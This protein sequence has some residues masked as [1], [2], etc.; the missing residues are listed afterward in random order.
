MSFKKFIKFSLVG[1]WAAASPFVAFADE[2]SDAISAGITQIEAGLEEG[3][4][5]AFRA[6]IAENGPDAATALGHLFFMRRHFD[7]AA[8]M[9]G[10]S[11]ISDAEQA[12]AFSNY[13]IMA[14]EIHADDPNVFGDDFLQSGLLAARMAVA[15]TPENG[16][17][18]NN[19]SRLALDSGS[20]AESV[21][22]AQAAVE[23]ESDNTLFLSNLA[24]ALEASGALAEAAEIMARVHALNPVGVEYL[25]ALARLRGNAGYSGAAGA[26]ERPHCE[27]NYRCQEICPKS[28]IGGLMSVT[29]EIENSSA[30]MACGAGE[31]YAKTYN[32]KEDLPEYGI[33]IPG[34]NSGFSLAIPGVSIHV[35]V[36]GEGNID[37]RGEVGISAG[38]LTG[39]VRAD[40]HY[41]PSNGVN[42]DNMGGGVRVSLING[43]PAGDLASGLG[44]PPMTVEFESL[45]GEPTAVALEVSNVAAIGG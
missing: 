3:A 4:P 45:N 31:P 26:V 37:V 25:A 24:R 11:A 5:D 43:S 8:W 27:V 17:F 16:T 20:F 40:G 23:V 41:S 34:L 15:L 10:T 35:L 19:L 36:D 18:Q 29:C 28:I 30:Q 1:L 39:Y 42:V 21:A 14:A 13:A 7:A 44:Q 2:T 38:P 32:C 6:H 22:A 33:L 9:F 12:A